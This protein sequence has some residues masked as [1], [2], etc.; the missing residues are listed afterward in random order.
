MCQYVM[1]M[2]EAKPILG[3]SPQAIYI[4]DY[5]DNLGAQT[6]IIEHNYTDR[7]YIID[8]SKFFSRA[9][10]TFDRFTQRIHFFTMCFTQSEFELWILKNNMLCSD[11]DSVQWISKLNDNYAGFCIIK[12]LKDEYGS[13]IFGRTL[14]TPPKHQS[15][16]YEG[17]FYIQKKYTINLFGIPLS[18]NALPFQVQDTAVAACATTAL[19]VANN[20]L[21]ELYGTPQLSPVEITEIAI[22]FMEKSRNFPSQGL[23][24]V[25]M[26]NFFRKINLDCDVININ[27]MK[28]LI[29]NNEI[30]NL[31]KDKQEVYLKTIVPDAIKAFLCAGNPIIAGIKLLKHDRGLIEDEDFHSVVICG[32]HQDDHGVI[33]TLYVHDDQ[34]GPYSPVKCASKDGSFLVWNCKWQDYYDIDKVE[35]DLLIIPLYSKI[36]YSFN[37]MHL[38]ISDL[39]EEY[40]VFKLDFY[41]YKLQDYKKYILDI[42]LKEKIEFL[43]CPLP[44]F[45]WVIRSYARDYHLRDTIIDAT[46]HYRRPIYEINYFKS[47]CTPIKLQIK[48]EAEP[49]PS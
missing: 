49:P 14:L 21:Q 20:K 28:S 24:I 16:I 48:K 40:S 7:D 37:R 45:L 22:N 18:I 2:E 35:L 25:E 8:Y 4:L 30:S 42:P 15:D 36:R 13:I 10:E 39:R 47:V 12:P 43:K 38:V 19:W 31:I 27:Y 9:H 17:T 5:L 11:S 44:R 26:L 3:S 29:D 1:P 33:D 41:L 23:T 6:A 46:S 34:I 32:Y